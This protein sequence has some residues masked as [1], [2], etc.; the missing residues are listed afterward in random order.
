[1]KKYTRAQ[2]LSKL[3]KMMKGNAN[4]LSDADIRKMSAEYDISEDEAEDVWKVKK[5]M[6]KKTDAMME[7]G[8]LK[9]FVFE[10]LDGQIIDREKD[11]VVSNLGDNLYF[12]RYAH[13][14][15]V[16]VEDLEME[17]LV[18]GA[19]I[20]AGLLEHRTVR[21][22]VHDTI[23]RMKARM[24]GMKGRYFP[25][26]YVHAQKWLLNVKNGLLDVETL[27]LEPHR[28]D[29]FS[30]SQAAFDYAPTAECPKFEKFVRD[31][32]GDDEETMA[33]LQEVAGY[34]LSNG[35]P[36]H[37]IFYLYGNS[38]RNGKSTFAQIVCGV[39]GESNTS[40]L[41][42][43][44]LVHDNTPALAALVGAQ[45]NFSDEISSKYI[46]SPR[47]ASLSAGGTITINPKYK[48]QFTYAMKAKL[49]VACNDLPRFADAQ[50]MMVRTI[51]VE[52]K[53]QIQEKDRIFD[54]HKELIK[55]EGAGIL[56][57]MMQGYLRLKK[58]NKF[59]MGE[60]TKELFEEYKR[61]NNYVLDYITD[62]EWFDTDPEFSVENEI[63]AKDLFGSPAV[64][65][66]EDSEDATG[67]FRFCETKNVKPVSLYTFQKEL[68]RIVRMGD[69][70]LRKIKDWKGNHV[71]R[72]LKKPSF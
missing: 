52:F 22:R 19:M 70:S 8:D 24:M 26:E 37:R 4:L 55:D 59:T 69:V 17:R 10:N 48:K 51:I 60:R 62:P 11:I 66:G 3:D 41:P 2:F 18:D 27:V 1:M 28:K 14:V 13:G 67:F 71:Y 30:L 50:G 49:L 12:Y 44:S 68:S 21:R 33:L 29:Y 31:I 45:V 35:N 9:D 34:M 65:A 20:E 39:L 61:Q 23:E 15:Y 64:R 5:E 56:Q 40:H 63:S 16:R 72:G 42:L 38:G 25:E 47:L 46:D 7:A 6:A 54:Y 58:N 32:M 57:W 43:E 36:R 53:V